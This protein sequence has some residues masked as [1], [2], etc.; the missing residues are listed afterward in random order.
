MNVKVLSVLI[1]MVWLGLGT[2]AG[3]ITN[4]PVVEE[5]FARYVRIVRVELTSRYTIIDMEYKSTMPQELYRLFPNRRLITNYISI[6]PQSR[7]Y[8]PG[9]TSKKYNFIRAEGIPVEPEHLNVYP[10][11]VVNFRLYYERLDPGIEIFDFFEGRNPGQTEYWNFYGVH[12]KNPLRRPSAPKERPTEVPREE[13]PLASTPQPRETVPDAAPQAA[14]TAPVALRGTVYDAKTRRAIPAQI[15][16]ADGSDTLQMGTS[17]GNYRLSLLPGQRYALSVAAKGYLS[18]SAAVS[19]ADSVGRAALTRDFYLTPLA[20]G[21]SFTLE[22][23]YFETSKFELLRE[24][25]EE[26][27]RL[28]TMIQDNP[29]L[30]VRVEGHT[31]NLGDFD[32]NLE[33]SRQRASAVRDYLI[34]KGIAADRIEA[35]GYGSTRPVARGT[36][37]QERQR[38]RRVEFVIVKM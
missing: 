21:T 25:Y 38:N 20:A 18:T 14:T 28:V 3:Q 4:R 6:D 35:K 2:A 7:L 32:K 12:I 1:G 31:D 27:D 24:S 5:Q 36:S 11:D 34:S 37:E 33:L 17:S 19:P 26:L 10:G 16:Y 9:N 29:S 8:K 23:I 15:S 22:N 30:Q 13:P